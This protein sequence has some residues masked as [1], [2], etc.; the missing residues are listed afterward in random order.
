MTDETTY[1]KELFDTQYQYLSSGAA[2][3]EGSVAIAA[4]RT[5]G[6]ALDAGLE[7]IASEIWRQY[8]PNVEGMPS[9]QDFYNGYKHNKYQGG[10]ARFQTG[11]PNPD[12]PNNAIGFPHPGTVFSNAAGSYAFSLDVAAKGDAALAG[13]EREPTAK[14]GMAALCA[15]GFQAQAQQ[16][17]DAI[18]S[19]VNLNIAKEIGRS[20]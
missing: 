3:K 13:G 17:H 16:L 6:M 2:A 4:G 12:H 7:K 19:G 10:F 15:A 20:S 5:A 1:A 18:I 14:W 9:L 8:I 11:V